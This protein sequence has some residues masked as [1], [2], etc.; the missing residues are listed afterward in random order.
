MD[1]GKLFTLPN[2]VCSL[3]WRFVLSVYLIFVD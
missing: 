2:A 3:L 1:D